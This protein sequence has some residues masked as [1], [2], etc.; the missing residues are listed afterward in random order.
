MA[1]DAVNWLVGLNL[2]EG[3]NH[4]PSQHHQLTAGLA[5]LPVQIVQRIPDKG[6]LAA[7][8]V[9]QLPVLIF[10]DVQGYDRLSQG[11]CRHQ[12]GMI[13]GAKVALEPHHGG[14]DDA[15]L[16]RRQRSLQ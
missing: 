1:E 7:A 6:P 15:L 14:H 11:G 5:Q 16:S 12:R 9:R 10:D 13:P 4:R 8:G 3:I 2:L